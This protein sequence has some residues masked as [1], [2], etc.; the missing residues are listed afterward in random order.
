MPGLRIL[1]KAES[2]KSPLRIVEAADAG[3]VLGQRS[4]LFVVEGL[5]IRLQ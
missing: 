1:D 3:L 4:E 5:G 2:P